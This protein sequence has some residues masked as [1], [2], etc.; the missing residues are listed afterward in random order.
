MS[1]PDVWLR[2]P[3][4]NLLEAQAAGLHKVYKDCWWVLD[5]NDNVLFYESTAHPK[6]NQELAMTQHLSKNVPVENCQFIRLPTAYVPVHA[7]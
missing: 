7:D 2:V 6:C 3:Y 4:T 5:E 1:S